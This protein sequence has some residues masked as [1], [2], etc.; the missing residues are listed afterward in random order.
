MD[1]AELSAIEV[2]EEVVFKLKPGGKFTIRGTDPAIAKALARITSR[3]EVAAVLRERDGEVEPIVEREIATA[4]PSIEV[5][6]ENYITWYQQRSTYYHPTKKELELMF[7]KVEPGDEILPDFAHSFTVRRPNGLLVQIDRKGRI[8]P[9]S[10][11]CPHVAKG[12]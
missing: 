9:P 4:V 2:E 11:Y 12:K 1:I 6:K 5:Q 8:S 10:P 7:S 3:D